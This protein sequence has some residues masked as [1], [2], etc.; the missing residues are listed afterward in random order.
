[1]IPSLDHRYNNE[2]ETF[3]S[4]KGYNFFAWAEKRETGA[5][6]LPSEGLET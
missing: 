1:M 4:Q 5:I 3:F 6:L 2:Q